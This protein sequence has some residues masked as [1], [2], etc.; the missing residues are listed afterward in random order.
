MDS[1]IVKKIN[2]TPEELKDFFFLTNMFKAP[3]NFDSFKK[4]FFPHLSLIQDDG[5]SDQEKKEK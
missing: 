5:G 4:I 3:M 1:M 2:V